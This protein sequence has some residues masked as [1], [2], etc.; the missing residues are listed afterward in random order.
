[1]A[2]AKITRPGLVAIG[3]LVAVLWG[4]VLGEQYFIR[5]TRLETY[6]AMRDLRQLRLHRR[7]EPVSH[8]SFPKNPPTPHSSTPVVG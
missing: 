7:A 2:L 3:L 4:C 1:M 5:R 8:P 6:R